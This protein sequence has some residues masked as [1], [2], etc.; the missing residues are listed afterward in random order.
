MQNKFISEF[1]YISTIKLLGKE[2]E[3]MRYL[4]STINNKIYPGRAP[5]KKAK[6]LNYL[7][8]VM[9]RAIHFLYGS[10]FYLS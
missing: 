4:E 10:S 1:D 6:K 3:L 5:N 9:K 2:K 7:N 8:D